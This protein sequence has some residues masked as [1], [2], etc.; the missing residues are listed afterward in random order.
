MENKG[1]REE[2]LLQEIVSAMQAKKGRQVV[3]LDLR[4]VEKSVCDY[5]VICNADNT[6]HIRAIAEDVERRVGSASGEWPWRMS[7]KENAQWIVLDYF[8][9]VVHIF[10]TEARG[11]YDL[12][13]LW[14]D[15][16][17]V[18]FSDED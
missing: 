2:I 5:F 14:A 4:K 6:P 13:S 18:V 17:R 12:E 7:G 3:Q 8:D 16:E 15:A 11:F 9:V 10:S 1:Q